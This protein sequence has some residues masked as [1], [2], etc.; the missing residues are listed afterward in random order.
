M[1]IRPS[2]IFLSYTVLLNTRPCVILSFGCL[3]SFP[4]S[5]YF[6]KTIL[7]LMFF[8][9]KSSRSG[10][11]FL[12]GKMPID[13][14]GWRAGIVTNELHYDCYTRR[15]VYSSLLNFYLSMASPIVSTICYLYFF[16]TIS[17]FSLPLSILLTFL[18]INMSLLDS[19]WSAIVCQSDEDVSRKLMINLAIITNCTQTMVPLFNPSMGPILFTMKTFSLEANEFFR[20][21]KVTILVLFR[22]TQCLQFFSYL[23]YYL[24]CI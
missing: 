10:M 9:S 7:L 4:Q 22:T 24:K 11:V 2:L 19:F 17:V 5:Y 15:S 8:N 21:N 13:T 12:W 14:E 3:Y 16:I 1:L 18:C 20:A 23:I 6:G